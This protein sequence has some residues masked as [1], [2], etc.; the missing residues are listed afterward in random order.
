MKLSSTTFEESN[1]NFTVLFGSGLQAF[2]SFRALF[3]RL[4]ALVSVE[5]DRG[6]AVDTL[7]SKPDSS[8]SSKLIIKIESLYHHISDYR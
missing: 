7:V 3:M 8:S 2:A 1:C 5:L 4:L 6:S